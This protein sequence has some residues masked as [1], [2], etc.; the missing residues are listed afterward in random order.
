M[1]R[2]PCLP[3]LNR[4][5]RAD[6]I[7]GSE[8]SPYHDGFALD[9]IEQT[10]R[11]HHEMRGSQPRL[12]RVERGESMLYGAQ[13]NSRALERVTQYIPAEL[14]KERLLQQAEIALVS[15]RAGVCVSAN[16]NIGQFDSHANNDEDQMKLIPELLAG[17]AWLLRRA[18][19]LQIRD[20]LVVIVQSEMGRTPKYNKGHG[21]DHWSI[22]SA[23]FLGRGIQGNRVIGATNEGQFA[24]PVNPR[25]LALD[26]DNGIAV[27]PEHIHQSLREL[28]GIADHPLS[29]KFPTG[30]A[31]VEKLQNIWG[32]S[33]VNQL[34][35]DVKN[36][37]SKPPDEEVQDSVS[38]QSSA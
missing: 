4:I 32:M 34:Q 24:V 10:L 18:E 9:R 28:A 31:E 12:P 1:S 29:K 14:P 27:R 16:L 2:V 6:A 35:S 5:A 22:G 23:M 37:F 11:E 19:E 30:V 13:V 21:K 7:N 33:L 26:S 20:R 15:F 38:D 8:R 25:T 36:G 3:S 17:I